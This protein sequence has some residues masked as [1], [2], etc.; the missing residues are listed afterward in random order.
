MLFWIS[1]TIRKCSIRYYTTR[2]YRYVIVCKILLII[3]KLDSMILM[4]PFQLE[5]FYGLCMWEHKLYFHLC[6]CSIL[7]LFFIFFC[8]SGSRYALPALPCSH[9]GF[10]LV[11]RT[12]TAIE[13]DFLS[14]ADQVLPHQ[15]FH[16]WHERVKLPFFTPPFPLPG[17]SLLSKSC[18][19]PQ[20]WQ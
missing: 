10:V 4:G 8:V 19:S 6:F 5:I 11:V 7:C 17:P 14:P 20:I 12:K 15:S 2:H 13:S 1:S 3:W 16:S 18:S 9:E